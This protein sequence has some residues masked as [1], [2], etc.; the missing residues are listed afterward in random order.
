MVLV[1]I[2][3]LVIIFSKLS[4]NVFLFVICTL[5]AM[6]MIN[7]KAKSISVDVT[8]YNKLNYPDEIY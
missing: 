4:L 5:G 7:E 8:Y 1:F 3:V 6:Y 2:T